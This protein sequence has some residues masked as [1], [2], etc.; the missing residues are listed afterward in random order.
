MKQWWGHHKSEVPTFK[1]KKEKMK[2]EELMGCI[3][4][5]L[6]PLLLFN[7]QDFCAVENRFWSSSEIVAVKEYSV[8][9]EE[10]YDESDS[11]CIN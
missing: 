7:Q 1:D 2:V 8:N 3:P 10:K 5:L 6:R 11:H 9:S 4:L